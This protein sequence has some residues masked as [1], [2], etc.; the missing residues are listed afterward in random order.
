MLSTFTQKCPSVAFQAILL[1]SCNMVW[2]KWNHWPLIVITDQP[3]CLWPMNFLCALR[4]KNSI[5]N[6]KSIY[7]FANIFSRYISI[8]TYVFDIHWYKN[9]FSGL[10]KNG[11][12]SN[13][14]LF[15]L[16]FPKIMKICY[17]GITDCF[18]VIT[19]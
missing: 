2:Y 18:A 11:W 19:E 6:L 1:F 5:L 3:C 14:Y 10:E 7:W 12:L 8:C 17:H 16:C 13:G 9:G 4:V 15:S